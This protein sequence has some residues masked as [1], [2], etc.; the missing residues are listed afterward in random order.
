MTGRRVRRESRWWARPGAGLLGVL[1]VLGAGFAAATATAPEPRTISPAAPR[2][3][4]TVP[5]AR[6]SLACPDPV[7]DTATTTSVSVAAPGPRPLSRRARGTTGAYDLSELAPDGAVAAQG[8]APG[9]SRVTVAPGSGPLVA[10]GL[11]SAAP[12]LAAGQLTRSTDA[13]MRGLAGVSC[14]A[15]VTDAWFVGSGA[16][17]GQRGRVYLTNPEAAPAVVDITLYGPDGPLDAPDARGVTVAPGAQEVRLLD[18]LAPGAE[19]FAVQVHARQGRISAAVRDLQVA[20]LTPLGADWVPV[21]AAPSRQAVVAGVPAGPGRR[22][23]Q[24][25]APGDSDAIVRLRIISAAGAVSPPGLDVIEVRAGSVTE[26]DLAPFTGE[27]PVSVALRADRPVTA[28][29]LA[30]VGGRA[31][32]LG[33]I[34]YAA[35]ATPLTPRTPGVV[36]EVSQGEQ[37]STRLLLTAPGGAA[38]VRLA[39]LPPATGTAMTVDVDAASLLEVDVATISP[40]A[41]YALVVS[42]APGSGPV[43]AVSQ[44]TEAEARGPMLTSSPVQPGRYVVAVPRVVADLSAGLRLGR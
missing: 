31:G 41:A 37:V 15:P 40:Q 33:D 43:L 35:A 20:G 26:V 2:P 3:A 7:V 30:R 32:L 36:T 6:A 21:A 23:L 14:T 34:A 39:P 29:V 1:T 44:V 38:V 16:V 27:Q 25:V 11:G 4:S 28:G 13:T 18:A 8:G 22:L 5:V 9:S 19:R 17:V 12:G 24:V 42:P 10:R